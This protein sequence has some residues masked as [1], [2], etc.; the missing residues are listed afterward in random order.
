MWLSTNRHGQPNPD[1]HSCTGMSSFTGLL[2]A[3]HGTATHCNPIQESSR[4]EFSSR[5]WSNHMHNENHGCL[6]A[7]PGEAVG[8]ISH[9]QIRSDQLST[10]AAP[11]S[12]Q[13][14]NRTG[15]GYRAA[16]APCACW[17][18]SLEE[19]RCSCFRF[20]SCAHRCYSMSTSALQ[21][22]MLV[23]YRRMNYKGKGQRVAKHTPCWYQMCPE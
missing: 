16:S 22:R 13:R 9:D 8:V 1:E 21:W 5:V 3:V 7:R 4:K 23:P 20:P 10:G 2:S 11:A 17:S 6:A 15:S 14:L 18:A 12:E 19:I